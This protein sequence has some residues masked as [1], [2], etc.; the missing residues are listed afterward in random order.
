[1]EVAS[2]RAAETSKPADFDSFFRE[3]FEDVARSVALIAG[4]IGAGQ[5]AAQEAFVRL[6]AR[7]DRME[8]EQHAR[9]FVYRVAV[10]V[11]RSHLRRYRRL[12]LTGLGTGDATDPAADPGTST[13]EW[14]SMAEALARLTPRQRSCV[15]LTDLAG[16]DSASVGR[17]LRI[18]PATVRVHL[19]R[20]RQMLREFLQVRGD[21]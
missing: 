3:R 12:I 8:S 14:L 9:N 5:D 16:L 20:A 15:V 4:D 6:H 13:V 1:M 2:E 11:V 17:I 7:W 10:N 21:T 19:M 18:E